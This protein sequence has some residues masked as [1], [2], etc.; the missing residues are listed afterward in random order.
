MMAITFPSSDWL[1]ALIEVLNHDDRYAEVAKNWEGDIFVVIDPDDSIKIQTSPIAFYLD[2][3]HGRCRGGNYFDPIP[4]ETSEAKFVFQAK[5]ANILK[6]FGGELDPMQ[7]MLT[8]R[9][10]VEGNMGYL[11]RNVP[12]VLD[13]I[14]CCR[15]VPIETE[16]TA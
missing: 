10:H 9:L 3:W 16:V 15:L 6:I 11:L 8:R 1:E 7:A 4:K 13:F 14:R 5:M 2:L 12:T